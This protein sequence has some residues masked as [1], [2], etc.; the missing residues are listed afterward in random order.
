MLGQKGEELAGLDASISKES[1]LFIKSTSDHAL[2]FVS[3]T[4]S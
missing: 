4:I 3:L 2:A 1:F